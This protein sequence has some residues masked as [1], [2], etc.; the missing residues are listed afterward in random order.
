MHHYKKIALMLTVLVIVIAIS[1]CKQQGNPNQ[2]IES[3][4]PEKK[5]DVSIKGERLNMLWNRYLILSQFTIYNDFKNADELTSEQTACIAFLQFLYN[6]DIDTL[7]RA[8]DL[9]E[10][11]V[12]IYRWP[13]ETAA[14]WVERTFNI[15]IDDPKQYFSQ[16]ELSN[17]YGPVYSEDYE[18]LLFR[19]DGDEK[20]RFLNESYSIYNSWGFKPGDTIEKPDGSIIAKVNDFVYNNSRLV[21]YTRTI[22]LGLNSDTGDYYFVSMETEY[23]N[24]NIAEMTGNFRQ[25]NCMNNETEW[26][27][28]CSMIG[29][30]GDNIF[31]YFN[32]GNYS[33][34]NYLRLSQV[35]KINTA[36]D[37]IVMKLEKEMEVDIDNGVNH[38]IRNTGDGFLLMDKNHVYKYDYD[39]NLIDTFDVPELIKDKMIVEW[40][41]ER[42][43][44]TAFFAGY[45]MSSDGSMVYYSCHEGL[46]SYSVADGELKLLVPPKKGE[47][48]LMEGATIVPADLRIVN[49][50]SKL[51]Y[52]I[53]GYEGVGSQNCLD[54]KTFEN[55]F[56][57]CVGYGSL[58][59][60]YYGS[61]HMA[62]NAD[63]DFAVAGYFD[64][65]TNQFKETRMPA[66]K[67]IDY[68]RWNFSYEFI[69]P[70]G[71]NYGLA[72]VRIDEGYKDATF[73][74]YRVKL[75]D[76]EI[77]KFDFEIHVPY[78]PMG[79]LQNG[80][81]V[82]YYNVNKAE[83]GLVLVY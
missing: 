16:M 38:S 45:D 9:E 2:D 83:Q 8:E 36:S 66:E 77:Q 65:A 64:F 30:D 42:Y 44:S 81:A 6:N 34:D 37:E 40:D 82:I 20:W 59:G 14:V 62:V 71:E 58:N 60:T 22:T 75:D 47:G 48:R 11:G 54:L 55:F 73:I 10:Y 61:G 49:G 50:D 23:M 4:L 26:L 15:K 25:L 32:D 46:W 29:E 17:Y 70:V 21:N 31:L 3:S 78:T 53:Y 43:R 67:N 52:T 68:T 1:S 35:W 79:I 57:P 24:N 76:M 12:K 28:D 63:Y 51:I 80:T 72:G 33:G 69:S 27:N 41:E 56:M 39:F 7:L 18:E 5:T 74:P 13:L 19:V